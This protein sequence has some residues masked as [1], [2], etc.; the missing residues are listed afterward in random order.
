MG[1]CLFLPYFARAKYNQ[2]AIWDSFTEE[3]PQPLGTYWVCMCLYFLGFLWLS[4][5]KTSNPWEQASMLPPS[6]MCPHP[7]SSKEHGSTGKPADDQESRA[8]Q[9]S[10]WSSEHQSSGWPQSLFTTGENELETVYSR[11]WSLGHIHTISASSRQFPRKHP[12]VRYSLAIF[13]DEKQDLHISH[14]QC[15]VSFD[16]PSNWLPST[17]SQT[18]FCEQTSFKCFPERA[19]YLSI[20][21]DSLTTWAIWNFW[22]FCW[23]RRSCALVHLETDTRQ[24]S[25]FQPLSKASFR[26]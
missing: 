24:K 12:R 23:H 21:L 4:L 9:L 16:S 13:R 19:T 5:G 22:I 10:Y 25:K 11:R 6:S 3:T 20:A 7:S 18:L 2:V 14:S 17:P 15:F 1:C 26:F 8:S